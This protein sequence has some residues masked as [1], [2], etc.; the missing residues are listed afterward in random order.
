MAAHTDV[1]KVRQL[2]VLAYLA[3]D[4]RLIATWLTRSK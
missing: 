1:A 3:A 2:E 4:H